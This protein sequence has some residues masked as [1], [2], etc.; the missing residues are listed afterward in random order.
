MR[1]KMDKDLM[2][3]DDCL[4]VSDEYG[5]A[6]TLD[7]TMFICPIVV[8]SK[9]MVEKMEVAVYESS[10]TYTTNACQ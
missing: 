9:Q 3:P 2:L 10:S 1:Q 4:Y 7:S 6:S 8:D 5:T